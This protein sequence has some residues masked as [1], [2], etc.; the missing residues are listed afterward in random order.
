MVASVAVQGTLAQE[1]R[2]SAFHCDMS[3]LCSIAAGKDSCMS[4]ACEAGRASCAPLRLPLGTHKPC[5]TFDPTTLT[6][7]SGLHEWTVKAAEHS[8]LASTSWTSP[9]WSAMRVSS[10]L[11]RLPHLVH[12]LSI[13]R[14]WQ[15]ALVHPSRYTDEIQTLSRLLCCINCP[16]EAKRLLDSHRDDSQFA[17]ATRRLVEQSRQ[18]CKGRFTPEALYFKKH[19]GPIP[20]YVAG[21]IA[22]RETPQSG[23]GLVVTER[24]ETGAHW[25]EPAQRWDTR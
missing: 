12:P 14:E 18:L 6:L 20:D 17:R 3:C 15:G 1:H 16:H 19:P 5:A 10:S 2:C 22:V 24:V 9:L 23:R 13:F 4:S 25:P 21:E 7:P 11:L 8:V